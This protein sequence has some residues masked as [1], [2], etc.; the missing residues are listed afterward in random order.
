MTI[1]ALSSAGLAQNLEACLA[2]VSH[3][4]A[5]GRNCV[6]R[7]LDTAYVKDD[8]QGLH[9]TVHFALEEQLLRLFPTVYGVCDTNP[10]VD[11]LG[12]ILFLYRSR[13]PCVVMG[14]NQVSWMETRH[15][16]PEE[17]HFN[18]GASTSPLVL[19]RISGGGCVY[20]DS[21]CLCFSIITSRSKYNPA[22]SLGVVRQAVEK[23]IYTQLK[24]NGK[25]ESSLDITSTPRSDLFV[26]GKKIT[27]SAMRIV[28]RAAYHHG[29]IL[30]H[31]DL[32]K[33]SESLRPLF[34]NQSSCEVQSK[35]SP[36]VRSSVTNLVQASG[37]SLDCT[38]QSDLFLL[39]SE[40]VQEAFW[41]EYGSNGSYCAYDVYDHVAPGK[42]LFTALKT[43]CKT[44]NVQGEIQKVDSGEHSCADIHH[45]IKELGSWEWIR[46]AGAVFQVSLCSKLNLKGQRE[47]SLWQKILHNR[48]IEKT[49]FHVRSGYIEDVS[50]SIR[51]TSTNST[52]FFEEIAM[53]TSSALSGVGFGAKFILRDACQ[54]LALAIFRSDQLSSHVTQQIQ[55]FS[56]LPENEETIYSD[57]NTLLMEAGVDV[58]DSTD[59]SRFLLFVAAIFPAICDAV[60][61]KRAYF[62]KR[63]K[64][65]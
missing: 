25:S 39:T 5:S 12:S 1:V 64:K 56:L 9:P 3:H 63:E 27:G 19:R 36:S 60:D 49:S 46:G 15:L 50:F 53:L 54:R 21:G 14:R 43:N 65:L 22:R 28:H 8:C 24:Q 40:L 44:Q 52:T 17:M 30:V 2:D 55:S 34:Q 38:P 37:N 61:F 18:D 20:H 26:A 58:R 7:C 32:A 45:R 16:H 11:S 51:S 42:N 10:R 23:L 29:T 57:M 47:D 4:I 13:Y 59:A 35:G 33:V 41:T 31:S 62:G 48:G 6:L